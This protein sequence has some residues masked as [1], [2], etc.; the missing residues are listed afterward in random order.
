VFSTC[1]YL[2]MGW[3]AI[4]AVRPLWLYLPRTGLLWLVAGGLAYTVGVAFFAAERM[5]YAHLVWHL[6]VMAGTACHF[7]AVFRYAA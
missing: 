1:L 6:F 5:R 2:G 3:L 4:I 7:V